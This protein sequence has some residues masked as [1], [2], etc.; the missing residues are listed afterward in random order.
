[1]KHEGS[2]DQEIKMD[3]GDDEHNSDT[4]NV[5]CNSKSDDE[6]EKTFLRNKS[7]KK[8]KCSTRWH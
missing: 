8:L 5:V 4:Y 1:M 6:A 2:D 3:S 7:K